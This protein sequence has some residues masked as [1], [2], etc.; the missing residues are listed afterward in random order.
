MDLI[1]GKPIHIISSVICKKW[2]KKTK[3]DKDK[4]KTTAYTFTHTIHVYR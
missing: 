2:R 1:T 4:T 3:N